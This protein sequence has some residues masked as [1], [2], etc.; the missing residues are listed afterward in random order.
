[1][2]RVASPESRRLLR[3]LLIWQRAMSAYSAAEDV[4][5]L[6]GPHQFDFVHEWRFD[7]QVNEFFVQGQ[8]F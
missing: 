3:F 5:R 1:V 8:Y 4:L 6:A 7:S 2:W